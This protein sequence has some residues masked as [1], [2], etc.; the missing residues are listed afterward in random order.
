MG[1]TYAH[2]HALLPRPPPPTCTGSSSGAASSTKANYSE[3]SKSGRYGGV[4][5]RYVQRHKLRGVQALQVYRQC[6]L[7]HRHYLSGCG[8][9]L[10][11]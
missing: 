3:R 7:D 5:E 6:L 10:D 11:S 9:A 2:A 4:V 8:H 1:Q